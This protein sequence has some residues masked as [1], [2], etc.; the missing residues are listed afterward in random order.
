LPAENAGAEEAHRQHRLRRSELPGDERP[1]QQDTGRER[2]DDLEAVPPRRIPTHESPDDPERGRAHQ[3]QAGEVESGVTPEALLDPG[4]DQRNRD[5]ADRD[6][7]PE[8]PLPGDA[9]G[10]RAAHERAAGD[11]D[12]CDGAEKADRRSP[13][14]GR[15]SGAEERQTQRQHQRRAGPLDCPSCDQPA[16][17][18]RQ[19]T[20]G[21]RPGEHGQPDRVEGAAPVPVAERSRGDQQDRE[22]QVVRVDGPLELLDRGAEIEPD[23]AQGG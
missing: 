5:Q 15:K 6:V 13:A 17:V 16:N 8:D 9:L 12:P 1:D 11:R 23:R 7:E 4:E 10:D 18:G 2:A 20:R 3:R 22:A 21:R 14:L 19:P